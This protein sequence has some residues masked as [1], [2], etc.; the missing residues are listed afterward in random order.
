MPRFILGIGIFFAICFFS[1]A[2]A[3]AGAAPD[4]KSGHPD[5]F[6]LLEQVSSRYAHASSFHIEAVVKNEGDWRGHNSFHLHE[7]SR[8]FDCAHVPMREVLTVTCGLTRFIDE[9]VGPG[10]KALFLDGLTQ[11]APVEL[12]VSDGSMESH[13]F[14][15]EDGIRWRYE[16]VQEKPHTYIENHAFARQS[17][18]DTSA[19]L[20]P[21]RKAAT[22]PEWEDPIVR[23]DDLMSPNGLKNGENIAFHLR[24]YLAMSADSV[25]NARQARFLK[26]ETISVDGR[27]IPCTVIT[28]VS[29]YGDVGPSQPSSIG[30]YTTARR[31]FWIDQGRQ[32]IVRMRLELDQ[33]RPAAEIAGPGTGGGP[34]VDQEVLEFEYP[35]VELDEPLP[36][37]DFVFTP[38]ADAIRS[39]SQE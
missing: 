14:L 8:A 10:S 37:A 6:A 24:P 26:N 15:Q 4:T 9:E 20:G 17:W 30:E 36:D 1:G 13:L 22:N 38:P 39:N 7:S 18:F 11:K 12:V 16:Y 34:F 2:R 33:T 35:L 21:M 25:R 28:F 29:S 5:P 27:K 3:Q 19:Q 32:V 23:R 31:T